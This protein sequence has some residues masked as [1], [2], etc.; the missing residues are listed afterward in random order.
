MLRAM[1]M[2][3]TCTGLY[4]A[5]YI[6]YMG[7]NSFRTTTN[8]LVNPKITADPQ[9]P[10]TAP[11]SSTAQCQARVIHRQTS[12]LLL[13]CVS[14]PPCS[15]P[16]S[17]HYVPV[18]VTCREAELCWAGCPPTAAMPLGLPQGLYSRFGQ[19]GVGALATSLTLSQWYQLG[20]PG[21]GGSAGW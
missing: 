17:H 20:S 6:S 13:C 14:P 12:D 21:Q 7:G 9:L 1:E 11:L 18:V 8:Y 3:W 4:A 15:C 10:T 2:T 16:Q 5:H 19:V